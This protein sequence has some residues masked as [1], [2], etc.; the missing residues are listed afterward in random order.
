MVWSAGFKPVNDE[1]RS[2]PIQPLKHK[3]KFKSIWTINI[4]IERM[5]RDKVIS[6]VKPAPIH[7]HWT[8]LARIK[9]TLETLDILDYHCATEM[10]S[11]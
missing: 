7:T 6:E 5:R 4:L 10:I 3:Y 9:K 11:M 1:N 8:T 2:D